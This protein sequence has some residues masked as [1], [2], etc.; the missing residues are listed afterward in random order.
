MN[1]NNIK[2]LI[3][4][5]SLEWIKFHINL[6]NEILEQDSFEID[7]EMS[8][9][10]GFNKVIKKSETRYD[11]II[12]DLEMEEILGE[13]Y[14][15]SWLVRN[16]LKRDEC[17]NSKILIVSGSH[18]IKEVAK[19]FNVDFIPKYALSNN[20]EIMSYKLEEIGFKI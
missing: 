1:K 5:D 10:A 18:D 20:P 2:I 7:F 12:S 11:L 17:K 8:A 15:G 3:V 6:L 19:G 14:A 13:N 4:E 9:R 16:I